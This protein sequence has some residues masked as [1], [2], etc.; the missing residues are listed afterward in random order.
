MSDIPPP[1]IWGYYVYMACEGCFCTKRGGQLNP[2]TYQSNPLY[3]Q[4][5]HMRRKC[6]EEQHQENPLCDSTAA[7]CT[8]TL[9]L[10]PI[11]IYN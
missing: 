10:W 1:D 8:H 6:A 3:A 2:F 7:F 11:T 9:L 5:D 4:A